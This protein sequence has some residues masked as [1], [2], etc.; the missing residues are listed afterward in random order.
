MYLETNLVSIVNLIFSLV[1]TKIS[2][3]IISNSGMLYLCAQAKVKI[4]KFPEAI[5]TT[6]ILSIHAL[7]P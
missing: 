6:G 1:N 3:T 7:K 2:K 4:N 5:K